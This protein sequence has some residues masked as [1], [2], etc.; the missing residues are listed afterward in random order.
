VKSREHI[1]EICRRLHARGW[2]AAADG[3]VSFRLPNDTILI[4]PTGKHKGYIHAEELCI[5]TLDN[6][7]LEGH[8]SGER[9]MHL[10]VYR[11]CPAAR[12]VIH[13]H[14]PTAVAWTVAQPNL[15]ELPSECLSE[16]IL[17]TGSIPIAPYA[18]PG[19]Q[20]MGDVLVP[21]LPQHRALILARHGALTWGEDLEEAYRGM[22]RIEH[23]AQTLKL[24]HDLGGLTTLP[25]GEIKYLKELRKKLGDT[26]L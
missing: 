24:A 3:N 6:Q 18:R 19:T 25:E 22:E 17:A 5:V 26:L 23:S 16:V 15:K 13:A 11:R 20:N 7:I 4:T 21:F 12:A 8:P 9:L 1:L 14:P 10:E 2:L